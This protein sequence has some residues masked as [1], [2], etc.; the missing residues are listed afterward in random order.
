MKFL[1]AVN[2]FL[3]CIARFAAITAFI[4]MVI[5][6]SLQIIFRFVLNIPLPWSE[7]YQDS[8]CMVHHTRDQHIYER[9]ETLFR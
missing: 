8:L 2:D 3:V 1:T 6:S 4:V 5:S 7:N 9:A